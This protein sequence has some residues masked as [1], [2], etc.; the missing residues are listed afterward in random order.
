MTATG[1]AVGINKGHV[2]TKRDQAQRP[3]RRKGVSIDVMIIAKQWQQGIVKARKP[4]AAQQQRWLLQLLLQ[5]Y[6][7]LLVVCCST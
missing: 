5:S 3:S 4:A 1:I 2:V 6:G 7:M